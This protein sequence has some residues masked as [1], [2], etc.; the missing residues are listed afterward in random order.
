MSIVAHQRRRGDVMHFCQ[1]SLLGSGI[2]LSRPGNRVKTTVF[3]VS[4]CVLHFGRRETENRFGAGSSFYTRA[5]VVV[6]ND[7][8]GRREGRLGG[9]SLAPGRD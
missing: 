8:G 9:G 7:G 1:T 4:G 2:A 5:V 3:C 6:C